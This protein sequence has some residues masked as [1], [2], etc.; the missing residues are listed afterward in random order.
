MDNN[1]AKPRNLQNYQ[2]LFPEQ[3]KGKSKELLHL[4]RKQA[5]RLIEIIT[6]QNNLHY[7]NNKVTGL[8]LLCR[9]CE[10]DEETLDHL[11]L[12]CPCFENQRR[13]RHLVNSSGNHNWKIQT[14]LEFS[15]I[16]Q[17]TLLSNMVTKTMISA[18][19]H[20]NMSQVGQIKLTW[21][22]W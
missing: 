18:T 4:R 12:E 15:S 17:L 8:E 20:S 7:I 5:R 9:F 2:N 10:E 21:V 3:H 19:N 22:G 13:Q 1:L 6:G 16:T 14:L 11:L